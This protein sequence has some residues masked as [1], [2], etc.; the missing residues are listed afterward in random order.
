VEGT[1]PVRVGVGLTNLLGWGAMAGLSKFTPSAL[2]SSVHK[3]RTSALSAV[4]RKAGRPQRREPC[5]QGLTLRF[6]C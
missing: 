1:N 3:S 6:A 2:G 5:L 4:Q